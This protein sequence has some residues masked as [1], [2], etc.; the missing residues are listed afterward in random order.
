MRTHGDSWPKVAT[1]YGAYWT[2]K[3][4]CLKPNVKAYP[5]YGGR[6]IRVCER[7]LESYE[8]FLAD[9]GRKP[10]PEYTLE[11]INNDGDY[12]PENCKWATRKE[13]AANRRKH[14]RYLARPR[15]LEAIT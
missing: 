2:M 15:T 14:G 13:Q 9:M 3:Q 11:R 4:R 1:E 10:G 12:S 7:W 5:N 8:N 6:G